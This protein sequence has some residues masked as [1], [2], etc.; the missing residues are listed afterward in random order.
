MAEYRQ[1]IQYIERDLTRKMVFLG[2]P[3]QVGKTAL[4]R[5]LLERA[6]SGR[7][8]NWDIDEDRQA[9]LGKSWAR[10]D[11]ILIFD[12]LHKFARWKN[13]IKGLY[14][15]LGD[16]QQ[17]LITGSA[18]LDVYRKGGDSLLGRY[19]Y[20]RLHPFS[21]DELP[22]HISP[23]E[24]LKR[25]LNIGGFPE[26]FLHNNVREARRWRRMRLDLVVR[27]DIRD[28]ES[29]HDIRGIGLLLDLL[30]ARVGGQVVMANIAQDLQVAPQTATRWVQVLERM[31]LCF[32]IMPY[33]RHLSRALRKAPKVYFFDN[34]DVLGNDGAR[35]ENLVATT[36][37]K[38]LHFIEDEY[39]YN[40]ELTY[41]RDRDG[42][43]VDFVIIIDHQVIEL[44]EV[45]LQDTTPTRGLRYYSHRLKPRYA[46]LLVAKGI[47]HY[48]VDNIRVLNILDY[49][50]A[51]LWELDG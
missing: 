40:C 2:G 50:K 35:F 31:Y 29:L 37:L 6:G 17:I 49:A 26:P 27:E 19:H 47:R 32:R 3:R 51:G 41:L 24:A 33:N 34:A 48:D 18:R 38:R 25:L 1:L 30:R 10:S 7:Y 8:F 11:K 16:Q 20:W 23:A 45:K 42:R 5:S 39:G 21:L 14:D 15:H 12:E 43:E 9:I 46:T 44:I 28:L 22:T 4:A 13:W 36:L